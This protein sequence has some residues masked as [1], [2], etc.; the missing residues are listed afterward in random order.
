MNTC[1]CGIRTFHTPTPVAQSADL[2][3]IKMVYTAQ[4]RD[5]LTA[6]T[7]WTSH[8]RTIDLMSWLISYP[9]VGQKLAE[10]DEGRD[11]VMRYLMW[12]CHYCSLVLWIAPNKQAT[13]IISG[14][15]LGSHLGI[16]S[17][18]G[19]IKDPQPRL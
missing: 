13:S 7:Q 16:T 14:V 8:S 3:Y 19:V 12:S 17:K 11:A 9:F 2:H 4:K 1:D 10:R 15:D 18:M 6:F 5:L